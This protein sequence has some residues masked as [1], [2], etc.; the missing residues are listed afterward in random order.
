MKIRHIALLM[1]FVLVVAAVIALQPRA[2]AVGTTNKPIDFTLQDTTGKNVTLSSYRGKVVVLDIWATWCGY[3]VREIPGLIQA[4]QEAIASKQPVQFIGIAIDQNPGSVYQ[5]AKHVNFNYPVVYAQNNVMKL[6]G[7]L[8]GVPDKF[9]VDK[10]GVMVE[11]IV[12]AL[13]KADLQ[14]HIAK[15]LK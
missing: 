9:I 8:P 15:Y 7:D 13:E 6:F 11:R 12:G 2:G 10:N 14:K 5:F 3:C 4:Q 1:G